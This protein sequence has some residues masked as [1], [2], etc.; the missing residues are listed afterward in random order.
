MKSTAPV[1]SAA[2][3]PAYTYR[4]EVVKVHDGDTITLDVDLGMRVWLRAQKVRLAGLNAPELGRPDSK[5]EASR[6]ELIRLLT[7]AKNLVVV[8]THKD[9]TEKWGRWL[10]T[11]FANDPTGAQL[12]LNQQLLDTGFAI[13]M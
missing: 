6:D 1:A 3:A 7:V 10:A 13:P 11:V 12:N 8:Q 2:V 9:D 5:G 4:A